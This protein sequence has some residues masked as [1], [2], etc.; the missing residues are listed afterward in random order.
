MYKLITLIILCLPISACAPLLGDGE[1]FASAH[2]Q[3]NKYKD[4][5]VG[6]NCL[7]KKIGNSSSTYDQEYMSMARALGGGVKSGEISNS[8]ARL[9]LTTFLNAL[10]GRRQAVLN[11]LGDQGL[12]MMNQPYSTPQ[13]VNRATNCQMTQPGLW[14]CM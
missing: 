12:Q 1:Y 8:K 9:D 4:Y 14:S 5:A 2:N 7:E 11:R 3:C 13:P 10:S 6:L